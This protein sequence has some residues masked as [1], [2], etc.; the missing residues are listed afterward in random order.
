MDPHGET[1]VRY[2]ALRG[3]YWLK[4]E[5]DDLDADVTRESGWSRAVMV[6]SSAA[7]VA[8]AVVLAIADRLA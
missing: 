5:R 4:P 3:A 6:I 7:T 2:A 1:P 8:A